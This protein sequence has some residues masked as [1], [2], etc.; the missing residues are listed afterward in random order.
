VHFG[1]AEVCDK[2]ALPPPRP[3]PSVLASVSINTA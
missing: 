2:K 3:A 1:D